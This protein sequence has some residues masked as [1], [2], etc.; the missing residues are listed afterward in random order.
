MYLFQTSQF[1]CRSSRHVS[2]QANIS[3]LFEILTFNL[4]KKTE[5]ISRL[6]SFLHNCKWQMWSAN[7]PESSETT[8]GKSP[9]IQII[10]II[11]CNIFQTCEA[12]GIHHDYNLRAVLP[13]WSSVSLLFVVNKG[14]TIV[15]MCMFSVFS[16]PLPLIQH[17]FLFFFL[18]LFLLNLRL[19]KKTHEW[20]NTIRQ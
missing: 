15:F 12:V 11:R 2:F 1:L 9:I 18:W 4:N 14:R 8:W 3:K 5:I 19:K 7:S 6:M 20:R 10:T 17:H 13:I 16:F